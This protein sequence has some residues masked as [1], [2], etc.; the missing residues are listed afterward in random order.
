[1]KKNIN[2]SKVEAIRLAND[3]SKADMA[4]IMGCSE[5]S[6][7]NKVKGDRPF[8]ICEVIALIEHFNIK[9][10]DLL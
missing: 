9:F 4:S 3:K 10:E 6:Y 7:D 1:M 2:V 8:Q 5:R